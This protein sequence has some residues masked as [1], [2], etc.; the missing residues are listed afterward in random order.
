MKTAM[1]RLDPLP[2][3][4]GLPLSPWIDTNDNWTDSELTTTYRSWLPSNNIP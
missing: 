2:I 4:D 3:A 1:L